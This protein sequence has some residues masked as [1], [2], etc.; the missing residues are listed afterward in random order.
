MNPSLY[1]SSLVY[2]NFTTFKLVSEIV[3]LGLL[4]KELPEASSIIKWK[5][6]LSSLQVT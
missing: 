3:G 5:G 2:S 6:K 4:I 1:K